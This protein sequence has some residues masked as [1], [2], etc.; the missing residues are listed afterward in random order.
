[1]SKKIAFVIGHHKYAKGAYSTYLEQT[2][3]D[4]WMSYKKELELLGDVYRHNPLIPSY[5]V[6]QLIM[7]KKTKKYDLVIELHFNMFNGSAEGCE[8]LFYYKNEH[9]LKLSLD[10]CKK[11]SELTDTY[12]RGAKPLMKGKRGYYFVKYQKPNAI[13][14]EPFF[15]DN[16]KDCER[17]TFRK[18]KE[19][20][21]YMLN[22]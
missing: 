11:Y 15:G 3:F 1:M 2:E 19:S 17:F 10:F 14:L 9:T 5:R 8:S 20:I 16:Q 4:F 22:E 7:A 12:N 13:L 6:R 18:F 21:K